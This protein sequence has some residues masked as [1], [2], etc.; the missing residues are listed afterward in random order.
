MVRAVIAIIAGQSNAEGTGD[1]NRLPNFYWGPSAAKIY[2]SE[3]PKWAPIAIAKNAVRNNFGYHGI[4]PILARILMRHYGSNVFIIKHAAGG[5]GLD[6]AAFPN[7]WL[8]YAAG[9]AKTL[10]DTYDAAKA[11]IPDELGVDATEVEYE[12]LFFWLQGE[13]DG[14][15]AL[16]AANYAAN[17]ETFFFDG[18]NG[19]TV[20]TGEATMP[21]IIAR[22][23]D[24]QTGVP[25]RSTIQTQQ[26]TFATNH[27]GQV[28]VAYTDTLPIL[29]D[30]FHYTSESVV[31]LAFQMWRAYRP[32]ISI[33]EYPDYSLGG[34]RLRLRD[35][36]GLDTRDDARV[37]RAINDAIQAISSERPSGWPW[38]ERRM[39]IRT[40]AYRANLVGRYTV[41]YIYGFLAD[42][43]V[44]PYL[45][46][47]PIQLRDI[48]RFSTETSDI[49]QGD[50]VID[51]QETDG[52]Q[53]ATL[54]A[55]Q[56]GT[57][58]STVATF[59]RGFFQLPKEC[60]SVLAV[61]DAASPQTPI[62]ERDAT[63]FEKIR[64]R[65]L[66]F[67]STSRIYAVVCD[68]LPIQ[69]A[70]RSDALF[71]ALYPFVSTDAIFHVTYAVDDPAL[72]GDYDEPLMPLALR[73]HLLAVAKSCMA[74]QLK[75]TSL[76]A[77]YEQ[78]RRV[79]L[80]KL[81]SWVNPTEELSTDEIAYDD[82][83]FIPGP[84]NLPSWRQ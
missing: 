16:V 2:N 19:A 45:A 27:S 81:L 73:P 34:M 60:R 64:R 67:S 65:Q 33:P 68:P 28:V 47:N 71:L 69:A 82:A 54:D 58:G 66:V 36:F 17:L 48:V 44:V 50:L 10:W 59:V 3:Y 32:V 41:D 74:A 29:P 25:F 13:Q 56:L 63:S 78:G 24:L 46:S 76:I 26:D 77:Y 37:D 23:S 42:Q 15:T 5:T 21:I 30:G 20:K 39:M 52:S 70:A 40:G 31:R 72:V 18:T 55:K 61:Y 57:T 79:A 12:H 6:L 43:I 53:V 14:G 75:E 9:E 1:V 83:D 35:E 49:L 11:L 80:R 38:Q 8:N 62:V 4:E 84:P 51:V 7:D 22:L